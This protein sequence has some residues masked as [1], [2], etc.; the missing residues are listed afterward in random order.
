M[1]IDLEN[2]KR[3]SDLQEGSEGS[4]GTSDGPSQ[5]GSGDPRPDPDMVR[6]V[7]VGPVVRVGEL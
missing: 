6:Q 1:E 5:S 4:D 2:G 3:I 7:V